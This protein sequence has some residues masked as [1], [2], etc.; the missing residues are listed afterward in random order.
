MIQDLLHKKGELEHRMKNYWPI[1][2]ELAMIDG[3]TMKS[4][5]NSYLLLKQIL[6][7]LHS[8]YMDI[9]KMRLLACESVY[10]I[11]INADMKN[12]VK[13]CSTYMEYQESQPH[14]KQYHMKCH[15]YNGR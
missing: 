14:E 4:K 1:K 15:T 6:H 11:D 9:E 2:S 3:I 7:Q 13:Q 12:T 10:R 5:R 8:N